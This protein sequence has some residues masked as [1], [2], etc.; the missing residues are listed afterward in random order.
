MQR[1]SRTRPHRVVMLGF[2][3]A[4]V[5]DIT[6][7]LEVFSR[8]A[9]WLTEHR[10]A[11]TPAYATELVAA[12]AGPVAMSNGLALVAARRYAEVDDADTLL[13]AGGIG[14]EAAA[15]D[16]ALL[17]WLAAQA[18]RVKRLGS[19]CNGAMIL[20][21]AGLLDGRPATTHWSYLDR[22]A[23]LAPKARVDRDA[24]YVR[25]GNIYTSA[26]VTAGM[27]LA[28]ALV[29]QDH[30]KAVALAVAQ[31]LVLF[32]K[33]PGGQS[34]FSR[35]LE[36]QKRDDL[37]GELELWMLENPGK[38]LSVE[39]LARRMSMSPRHFARLF[40]ARLGASPAAYVRRLRVEQ[41]RRR[42][43]EGASRFKQ[44][45]R[46]CGFADE[47]ALRRGFQAVVGIT[48]AEYRARF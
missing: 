34:Q 10:G 30:G 48:P 29:E 28:L 4:Q 25:S 47:Q 33:R 39:A 6:G 7:P 40:V 32:L 38:D 31:E 24:L 3:N 16:R 27:D 20:A 2:P 41:A 36:A 8:T 5:L 9:R 37:F 35:H 15:T 44:L 12:R 23:K 21:A 19:I 11:R 13:V 17:R 14:W 43:E 1:I 22:L 26:G 42:I 45:A 46:E 18:G